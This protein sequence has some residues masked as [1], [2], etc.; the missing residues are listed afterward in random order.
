MTV[1]APQAEAQTRDA[2]TLKNAN[3]FTKLLS[4]TSA[5]SHIHSILKLLG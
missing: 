1:A 3:K 4:F 5:K 2:E